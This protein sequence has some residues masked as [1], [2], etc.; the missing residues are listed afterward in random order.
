VS[1]K[2]LAMAKP[3]EIQEFFR[4]SEWAAQF[5]HGTIWELEEI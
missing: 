1:E 5:L 3:R 2:A 4:S